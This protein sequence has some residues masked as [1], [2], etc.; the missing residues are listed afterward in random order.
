M[1]LKEF[2]ETVLITKSEDGKITYDTFISGSELK[3]YQEIIKNCDEFL[4]C[5]NLIISELPVISNKNGDTYHIPTI[6][7]TEDFSVNGTC[8]LFGIGLT[9]EMYDPKTLLKPVKD[10]AAIGPTMYNPMD[11]TPS[12]HIL[13]TW[14]PEM[15]QDI[16]NTNQE[17][18]IKNNLRKLL[19]DVLENPEEYR[20][21]GQR[22]IFLRGL[23]EEVDFKDGKEPIRNSFKLD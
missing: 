12:K 11:F 13:L 15:S 2:L 20:I 18:T 8:C 4:N 21:K 23:F 3:K 16:T 7:P 22:H 19:D 5:N 1:K 10:G 14:N 6:R 17:V 9:P